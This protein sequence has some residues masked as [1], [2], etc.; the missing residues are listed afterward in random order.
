MAL[1]GVL[2]SVDRDLI[3]D[4]PVIIHGSGTYARD[5]Y[6]AVDAADYHVVRSVEDVAAA[7]WKR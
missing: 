3:G 5:D 2:N 6:V 1:T 4:G 7:V